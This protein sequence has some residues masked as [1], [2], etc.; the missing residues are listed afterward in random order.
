MPKSVRR[1]VLIAA[2]AAALALAS[3]L[4]PMPRAVAQSDD[5]GDAI[6]AFYKSKYKDCDL[7]IMAKVWKKD[8]FEAKPILGRQILAHQERSIDAALNN[9]RQRGIT[10]DATWDRSGF[11]FADAPRIAALWMRPAGE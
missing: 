9:A 3:S 4:T 1:F 5:D 6:Q 8:W 11:N 2:F 10:C 7:D